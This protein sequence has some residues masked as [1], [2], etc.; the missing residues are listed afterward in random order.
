MVW[1]GKWAETQDGYVADADGNS[2]WITNEKSRAYTHWLRQ[3][4]D[5]ILVGAKTWIQDRP[6]LTVRAC[7]LP[8]RRNPHRLVFDPKGELLDPRN[9]PESAR[10][11]APVHIYVAEE[12]LDE[13][14]ATLQ[15]NGIHWVPIPCSLRDPDF[16]QA[17]QETVEKTPFERPLQSVFCE[18]GATLL[19]LL[20]DQNRLDAVHRFTATKKFDRISDRYRMPLEPFP[21][22][23]FLAQHNFDGDLLRDWV[24]CF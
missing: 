17:F 6:E 14:P 22:W 3:K 9:H 8:H 24:N 21:N 2:K 19:R 7:A 15:I 12:N 20:I 18:G 10:Y 5:V 16:I 23:H 13:V 1:A 11:T 4:Y